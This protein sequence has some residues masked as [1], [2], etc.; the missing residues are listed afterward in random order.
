MFYSNHIHVS[1]YLFI[2]EINF[3]WQLVALLYSVVMATDL[4]L[5]ALLVSCGSKLVSLANWAK[6]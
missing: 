5:V 3:H 4:Y 6:L 2:V 1:A